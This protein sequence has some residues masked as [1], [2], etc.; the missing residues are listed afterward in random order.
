[1]DLC[2]DLLIVNNIQEEPAAQDASNC[3][4]AL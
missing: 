1:M 2:E 4:G 3:P